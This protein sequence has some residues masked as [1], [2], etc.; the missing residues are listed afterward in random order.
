VLDQAQQRLRER[1]GVEHATLQLE[2]SDHTDCDEV[3]W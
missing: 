1:H 2:P 3:G